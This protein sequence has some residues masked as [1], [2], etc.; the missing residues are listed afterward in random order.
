MSFV[1]FF[2]NSLNYQSENC[3]YVNT[4]KLSIILKIVDL[5]YINIINIPDIIL[6]AVTSHSLLHHIL[7]FLLVAVKRK[8]KI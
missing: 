2:K 1:N 6:E 8:N 7:M 4:Y 3:I 5:R